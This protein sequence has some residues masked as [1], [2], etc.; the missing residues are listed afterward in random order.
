MWGMGLG[1]RPLDPAAIPG[2]ADPYRCQGAARM[3]PT[4]VSVLGVSGLVAIGMVV[5]LVPAR[6]QQIH[7]YLFSGKQ[8][9]L[10]RGDAN[11]R[12]EEKEHDVSTQ[13]FHSQP[14]SEHVK[15]TSDAG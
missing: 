9:A 6:G 2:R 4:R 12:V 3:S 5:A 10:V 8:V 1:F 14:S 15:L 7:R 11:V 13:A